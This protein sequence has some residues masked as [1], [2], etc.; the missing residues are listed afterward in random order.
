LVRPLADLDSAQEADLAILMGGTS[1]A[2]FMNEANRDRFLTA[3]W[4]NILMLSLGLPGL[5]FALVALTTDTF[6]DLAAL[7]GLVIVSAFY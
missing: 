6:S 7:I 4:N 1:V 2:E 5:V 3:Q